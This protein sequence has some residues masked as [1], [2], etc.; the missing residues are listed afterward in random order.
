MKI[1]RTLFLL[2]AAG[3]CSRLSAQQDIL[4][5]SFTGN[6]LPTGWIRS[7]NNGSVGWEFGTA[8]GLSSAFFQIAPGNTSGIAASNDDKHDDASGTANL[9]NLDYL[10]S[11]PVNLSAF[12]NAILEFDAY[13]PGDFGSISSIEITNDGG[14]NWMPAFT[15]PGFN[16]WHRYYVDLAAFS[17]LSGL[18]FGFHHND[19]GIWA[20]GFAIDN[21]R[22]FEALARDL[23]IEEAFLDDFLPPGPNTLSLRIRNLGNQPVSALTL[24]YSVN[25]GSPVSESFTSFPQ[26]DPAQ[27]IDLAF[28]APLSLSGG[29]NV[30]IRFQVESVN[31][32]PDLNPENDTLSRSVGV[33]SSVVP[34]RPVFFLFS[35][36]WCSY[37]T[38]GIAVLQDVLN[39]ASSGIG[40][41]VHQGD[42]MAVPEGQ[43]WIS[44]WPVAFPSLS[45]DFSPTEAG[46]FP[47]AVRQ[48]NK[49]L[50][51]AT[52]AAGTV[53]PFRVE[54]PLAG[55]DAAT[56]TLEAFVEIEALLPL[57]GEHRI[58]LIIVEDRVS[59]TGTGYDQANAYDG[60]PGHPF[61]GLGDPITAFQHDHT[62]RD[63][64]GG[65]WGLPDSIP[66]TLNP[67]DRFT[68]HFKK[69]IPVSWE[70]SRIRLVALVQGF[71][72]SDPYARPVLNAEMRQ[73]PLFAT[74]L[75]PSLSVNTSIRAFPNPSAGKVRI[76][77][78]TQTSGP[79]SLQI[80]DLQ[81]RIIRELFS[82]QM[83][84]GSHS[85]E[86]N[87]KRE[88][89][90]SLPAGLYILEY[91][92]K[93][94]RLFHKLLHE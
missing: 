24:S 85:F 87:G 22:V 82:G 25:G 26:L 32:A 47:V 81:G 1:V 8:T 3:L 38:D 91:R 76:L 83:A 94:T 5:Q 93:E 11:P 64:L 43:T 34:K 86:W 33:V 16:D 66:S 36:A 46:G 13:A 40:L 63:A 58:N 4:T 31:G 28:T 35:G 6:S 21:V 72:A 48:R 29:E 41:I 45:A 60:T 70:E 69:A 80:T 39:T 17:T 18:S 51:I 7:Q 75:P 12:G 71:D 49:W 30:D 50:K 23:L 44:A 56:R 54:I 59:G 74:G 89:G 67:G 27:F 79:A 2:L 78:D 37:C 62:F 14:Q 77:I 61:A 52:E 88:D 10:I 53:P 57:S 15:V 90:N 73:L 65:S 84:T 68:F 19:N 42:S 92:T 55:W 20:G 9:A